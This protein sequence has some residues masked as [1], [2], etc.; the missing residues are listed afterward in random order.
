MLLVIAKEP[1]EPAAYGYTSGNP[2]GGGGGTSAA[3][4][5]LNMVIA[6]NLGGV[7]DVRRIRKALRQS[8]ACVLLNVWASGWPTRS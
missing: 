6:R 5:V 2:P 3:G 8:R 7:Q 1:D 4:T